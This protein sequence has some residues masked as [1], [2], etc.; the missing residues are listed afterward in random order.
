MNIYIH[1]YIYIYIYTYIYV[2]IFIRWE[3]R[4]FSIKN[5]VISVCYY[6]RMAH[7]LKKPAQNIFECIHWT[8][9][10][11]WVSEKEWTWQWGRSCMN[12]WP[13]EFG[14]CEG[15]RGMIKGGETASVWSSAC[16]AMSPLNMIAFFFNPEIYPFMP[17]APNNAP[18]IL[19]I[20]S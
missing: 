8:W 1:I 3:T 11:A 9:F 15:S 2:Y 20:A 5:Y 13:E 7:V 17:V 16:L 19:D 18:T 4:Y 6:N 14:R 12:T 10:M